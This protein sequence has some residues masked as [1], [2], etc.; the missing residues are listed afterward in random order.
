[1]LYLANG[2]KK[3]DSEQVRLTESQF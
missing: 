1:M 3:I 2:G